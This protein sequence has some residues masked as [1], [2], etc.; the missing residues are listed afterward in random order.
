MSKLLHRQ[1]PIFLSFLF[2]ILGLL[3]NH[4]G[5]AQTT[6]YPTKPIKLIAPVAAGGG[7]D[8]I[9]NNASNNIY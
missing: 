3:P 2:V 5:F 7:L 1:Q 4:K 9:L 8:A 6:P